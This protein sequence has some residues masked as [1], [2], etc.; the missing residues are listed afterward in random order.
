M[1]HLPTSAA[2]NVTRSSYS[3][4]IPIFRSKRTEEGVL[5]AH[6]NHSSGYTL[7]I[8]DNYLFYEYNFVGTVFKIQSSMEVPVGYS[9]IR[10]EFIRELFIQG[11]GKLYIDGQLAGTLYMPRTLP[12]VISVEGM[13]I[14]RDQLTPVSPNYP[15][16][17]FP[18]RGHIEKVV[19]ELDDDQEY[20]K[21]FKKEKRE[22]IHININGTIIIL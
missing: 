7:Y 19:I 21:F 16:P 8:K 3:I 22:P 11:T 13:D 2:P 15:V 12:F 10:F 14:G 5:I 17:E 4:T 20:S 9:T 6:G 1:A 18:F